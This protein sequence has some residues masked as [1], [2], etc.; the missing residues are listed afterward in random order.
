MNVRS[1]Y[2][3]GVSVCV[4]VCVCVCVCV[5][6][7]VWCVCE[8]ERQKEAEAE[9]ERHL[10]EAFLSSYFNTFATIICSFLVN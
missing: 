9:T 4:S 6:L 8:K 1:C 2:F 10:R 3:H 7:C 5:C